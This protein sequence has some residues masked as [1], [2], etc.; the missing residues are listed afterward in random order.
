MQPGTN[1]WRTARAARL[2]VIDEPARYFEAFV[3]AV[4]QAE[5][6]IFIVAWDIH[7]KLELVRRDT[8]RPR[9]L[10]EFLV[11]RARA[12]PELQI[13]VLLWDYSRFYQPERELFPRLRF[14]WSTPANLHFRIN[15]HFPTGACGHEKLVVIDD[16]LAFT[17]GIDLSVGRWD[18]REHLAED[19]RRV[20][21]GGKCYGPKHDA[22][23]AL[24]G[25]AARWLG[26]HARAL[27]AR[28]G[29]FEDG[30]KRDRKLERRD[31]PLW[32]LLQTPSPPRTH[33][34]WPCGLAADFTEVEVALA[35]SA[36]AWEHGERIDEVERLYLSTIAAAR[37]CLYIENQYV[38]SQRI[39]EALIERL[40]AEDGPEVVIVTPKRT[41]GFLEEVTIGVLRAEVACELAAHDRHGRLRIVYP[42]VACAQG[43]VAV[44]VHAKVMVCDDVLLRVGSSNLSNRSL[45][46]DTELDVVLRAESEEERAQVRRVRARLLAQH[47]GMSVA[48]LEETLADCGGSLCT[49]IDRCANRPHALLPL[50]LKP[51]RAPDWLKRDVPAGAIFDAPHPIDAEHV[52]RQILPEGSHEAAGKP[53]IVTGTLLGVVALVAT[54]L[55]M[56]TPAREVLAA[57]NLARLFEPVREHAWA[58]FAA[59]GLFVVAASLGV[60]LTALIVASGIVFG[61]WVGYCV[62]LPGSL[63]AC[64]TTFGMGHAIGAQWVERRAPRKLRRVGEWLGERGVLSV[65]ALRFV[66]VAP[67]VVTN[68]L[69]GASAIRLRDYALGSLLA[70]VPG[71]ALP[72]VFGDQLLSMILRPSAT[73]AAVLLGVVAAMLCLGAWVRRQLGARREAS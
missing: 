16:A 37:H 72:V 41:D 43:A 24:C 2:T 23:V 64:L 8:G 50:E 19:P 31:P 30:G 48:E 39:C 9:T 11:E 34:P 12:R 73:T 58:P 51:A 56:A 38:S 6:S 52:A 20:D 61:A 17:G 60:P 10:R 32:Q 3:D 47:L 7:S 28:A 68:L 40:E 27:W 66:P 5:R 59:I 46:A 62:A 54:A 21:P 69:A 49:L 15:G 55:V 25:E 67:F 70:L 45:G 29:V 36:P 35:R 4:M 14:A 44:Y 42:S 1:C 18:T 13:F 26:V 63:L 22:Q 57:E 33:T 53:W 65:M 71:V